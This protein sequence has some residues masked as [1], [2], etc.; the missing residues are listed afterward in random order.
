MI[1]IYDGDIMV[2]DDLLPGS[3]V[4][5]QTSF[6]SKPLGQLPCRTERAALTARPVTAAK[7]SYSTY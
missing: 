7:G 3:H 6:G 4:H 5:A 1:A 2:A